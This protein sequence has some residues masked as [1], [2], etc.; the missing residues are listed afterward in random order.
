M[1]D[2]IKKNSPEGVMLQLQENSFYEINHNINLV[3]RLK[4]EVS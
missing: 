3:K 1:V 2:Y 4:N